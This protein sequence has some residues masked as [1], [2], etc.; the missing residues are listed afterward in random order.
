MTVGLQVDGV[1]RAHLG[2]DKRQR[3]QRVS[4]LLRE[5]GFDQDGEIYS[6][7]AH[8]LSGGQRQRIAI[9]QAVACGPA[10]LIADEPTSKLDATSQTE[11]LMLLRELQIKRGT[12]VVLITHD[13]SLLAG[14]ANRIAVMYA[15]RIVEVGSSA[16]I[17]G[18]PLHPYTQALVRIAA[19]SAGIGS[20]DKAR[21]PAIDGDPPDLTCLPVGCRFEPRCSERMDVCAR[22]YPPVFIPE[23]SRPVNCFKYGE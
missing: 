6:A 20:S 4:E 8:Q 15:G 18:R 22:R 7:Y 9:A 23:G 10:L 17:F 14:F 21:L 13:P 2:L 12:S 1:L 16:A 3:R 5:V 19:S 11:I